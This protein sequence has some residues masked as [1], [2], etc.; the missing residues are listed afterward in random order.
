MKLIKEK[1]TIQIYVFSSNIENELYSLN[2]NIHKNIN[3]PS[4]LFLY[5]VSRVGSIKE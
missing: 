1:I 2:K 3:L 5:P 4:G